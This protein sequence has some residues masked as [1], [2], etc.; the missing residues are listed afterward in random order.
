LF[1]EQKLPAEWLRSQLK[2]IPKPKTV[3]TE[4]GDY[5]PICLLSCA[6]KLLETVLMRRFRDFCNHYDRT[7]DRPFLSSV[8]GGFRHA[9]G[10]LDQV[11]HLLLVQQHN[12]ANNAARGSDGRGVIAVFL[13]IEKAFDSV[14]H[15]LVL[16][17]LLAKG[18]PSRFVKMVSLL[19]SDHYCELDFTSANFE[20]A[21][22]DDDTLD[23][24]QLQQKPRMDN[25]RGAIQGSNSGSL[26]WD[27]FIDDLIVELEDA[28]S[29]CPLPR[30]PAGKKADCSSWFADDGGLMEH[31]CAD[32]Q[33]QLDI[34]TRWAERN[35]IRFSPR[36]SVAMWLCK[37][38]VLN[39]EYAQVG[40]E[41]LTLHNIRLSVVDSFCYLGIDI[42]GDGQLTTH[43][44]QS[45]IDR[46]TTRAEQLQAMLRS[47]HGLTPRLGLHVARAKINSVLLYGCD[48]LPPHPRADLVQRQVLRQI[49]SVCLRS[50]AQLVLVL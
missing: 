30:L 14:R 36:K 19:I 12:M 31:T 34:C 29:G 3:G 15:A 7:H 18:V 38:S 41:K 13:D 50:N 11:V 47:E 33:R 20:R 27:V 46:A 28:G 10:T 48:I 5:R 40:N 4:P 16:Q 49:V 6:F 42:A 17:K 37:P 2:L 26:L 45:K 32:M 22:L 23:A 43:C 1:S 21:A 9:R 35:R 24:G 8:Q 25:A 44:S 39:A